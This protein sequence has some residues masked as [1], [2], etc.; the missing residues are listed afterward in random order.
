MM[1]SELSPKRIESLAVI[2]EWVDSVFSQCIT[3]SE[4]LLL[5]NDLS[6][7]YQKNPQLKLDVESMKKGWYS[8]S[9]AGLIAGMWW[10]LT[11]S[12]SPVFLIDTHKQNVPEDRWHILTAL[13]LIT[14]MN[15]ESAEFELENYRYELP[16][17]ISIVDFK[18]Y[19]TVG[20]LRVVHMG[21]TPGRS[22]PE[23]YKVSS[24]VRNFFANRCDVFNYLME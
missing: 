19:R 15:E 18:S 9:S 5:F 4:F 2:Q 20:D 6:V 13:P 8:C 16:S 10:D 12:K 11:H 17:N 7:D 22:V 1:N 23:R 21:D 24:G 14:L 3:I